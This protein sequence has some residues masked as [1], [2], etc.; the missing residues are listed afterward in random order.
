MAAELL[1]RGIRDHYRSLAGWCVGIALYA[2]L[3]AA[4]FPSIESSPGFSKLIE[5]Y[6][7]ALKTLFGISGDFTTGPGYLDAELFSLILPLL[8][9]VL[10]IGS[11]A[12]TLAG[13]EDAGRLEL[14]LAYPIRRRDSVLAKGAAVACEVAVFCVAAFA[15]L[16]VLSAVFG[17]D[18]RVARLVTAVAAVAV[19]ALFHGWLALAVAALVPS[20]ALAIGLASAVAAVGYLIGGLEELAGWLHPFRFASSFWWIGQAPLRTGVS[21]SGAAVVAGAAAVCIAA[22]A[23]A[24]DRRDLKTP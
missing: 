6:P 14:V 24:F 10:A 8:A 21:G 16:I 12:R 23:L 20:R 17:L 11:A 19:L 18:L 15:A 3:L 9:I 1:R 2:T 5:S 13:D 7:D 22:A 4:V